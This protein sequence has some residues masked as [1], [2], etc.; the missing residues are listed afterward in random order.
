LSRKVR[1]ALSIYA[2]SCPRITDS[3][4]HLFFVMCLNLYKLRRTIWYSISKLDFV[5]VKLANIIL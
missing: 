4:V 1:I 5:A 2:K 3:P